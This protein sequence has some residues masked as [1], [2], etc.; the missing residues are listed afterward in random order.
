MNVQKFK[1][2]D[3]KPAPYNPRKTLKPGDDEWEAL[4]RSLERF[5]LV[6][7]LIINSKTGLLVSGHQRL[8]VLKSKGETEVEAVVVDL[9]EDREKLLNIALNKIEGDWDYE[10]LKALFEE[11]SDEDIAF[12]GFSED[13]LTNL[14]DEALKDNDDEPEKTAEGGADS[15]EK[16]EAPPIIKLFQIF[17]SFPSKEAAESWLKERGVDREFT[18]TGRNITIRM[19]GI[20]YGT[21]GD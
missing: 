4:S 6:E 1:I 17:L 12:T 14:F 16:P 3:I 8:N 9:D 7:P 18:E 21:E 15:T 5:G 10:K 20:N 11:I 2:A 13:E 19:E